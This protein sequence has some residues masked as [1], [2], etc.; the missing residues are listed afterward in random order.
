[1]RTRTKDFD[2][3]SRCDRLPSGSVRYRPL[4][5]KPIILGTKHEPLA[6]I[7][8]HYKEIAERTNAN[9]LSWV[10]DQWYDTHNFK[11]LKPRTQSDYRD[12]CS[13][14]PIKAF[15]GWDVSIIEPSDI[16]D[17]LNARAKQAVRRSNLELTW[18]DL[19]LGHAVCM[20]VIPENPCRDIKPMRDRR[21]KRQYVS[22][23]TYKCM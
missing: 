17:Y 2:L 12:V 15:A 8:A 11:T 20:G 6:D 23:F 19:V 9:T 10:A 18:L 1:M 22:D 16:G 14:T 4:G 13:K 5:G 21:K 7:W 3:P